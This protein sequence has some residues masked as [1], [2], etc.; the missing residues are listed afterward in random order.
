M[1]SYA[2]GPVSELTTKTTHQVFFDTVSKFPD[3]DALIV[4]H[5]NIRLTWSQL[6]AEVERTARGLIGLGLEPGDR[7][8]VWATNC[9]E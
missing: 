7:V 4:K 5:Q 2:R 3:R 8:G 1:D 6:A 9:A